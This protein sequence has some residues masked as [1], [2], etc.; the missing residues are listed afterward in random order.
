MIFRWTASTW[1]ATLALAPLC[2]EQRP[3][4]FIH[5]AAWP[6][7]DNLEAGVVVVYAVDDAVG[8]NPERVKASQLKLQEM[9]G[10]RSNEKLSD[11]VLYFALDFRV[12][13]ADPARGL[14]RV[15]R[16]KSFHAPSRPKTDSWRTHLPRSACF[17]ERVRERMA[18]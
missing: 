10:K 7:E 4:F 6:N 15:P 3:Q 17:N 1:A 12:E 11:P 9:P 16:T 14:W 8:S 18:F 5:V 13:L 2:E